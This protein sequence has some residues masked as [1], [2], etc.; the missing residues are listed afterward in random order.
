MRRGLVVAAV[1]VVVA[2]V[3]GHAG[4]QTVYSGQMNITTGARLFDDT[5]L[6]QNAVPAKARAKVDGAVRSV[7][8][9]KGYTLCCRTDSQLLTVA[10]SPTGTSV[11]LDRPLTPSEKERFDSTLLWVDGD[12]LVAAPG[13]ALCTS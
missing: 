6:V 12:V 7:P 11:V 3:A 2:A 5:T 13:S 9:Q 10:D 1:A 4:A 8:W